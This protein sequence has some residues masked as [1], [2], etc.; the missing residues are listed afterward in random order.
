[1]DYCQHV[2]N[3]EIDGFLMSCKSRVETVGERRFGSP[4]QHPNAKLETRRKP[5]F[6]TVYSLRTLAVLRM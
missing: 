6:A 4:F 3:S 1:M 2:F 5:R